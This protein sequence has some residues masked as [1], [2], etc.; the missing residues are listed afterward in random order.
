[1]YGAY[2]LGIFDFSKISC[3][4]CSDGVGRTGTFICIHS[5]L[6][7]LKTEGVVDFFQAA[8]SARMQRAGLIP[9]DVHKIIEYFILYRLMFIHCS[10]SFILLGSLCLLP[11][12]CGQLCR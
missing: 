8:K 9:D 4:L 12:G 1:M 7:R 5:Q 10:P 2:D 6:E 11:G 3:N